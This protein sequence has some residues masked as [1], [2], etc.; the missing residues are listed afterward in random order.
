[1]FT[2]FDKAS[3]AYHQPFFLLTVAEAKRAFTNMANDETSKINC[4]PQDF[5]L[6]HCGEYDNSTGL[7]TQD[8]GLV[9]LGYAHEYQ[10]ETIPTEKPAVK[11]ASVGEDKR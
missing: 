5:Q 6:F 3:E 11:L 10:G 9:N 7:I 1:M 4:Y 8:Q 2:I